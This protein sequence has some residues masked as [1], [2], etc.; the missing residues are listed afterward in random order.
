M[1]KLVYY[2]GFPFLVNCFLLGATWEGYIV[3]AIFSFPLLYKI[4]RIS[5]GCF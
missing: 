3:A 5:E 2:L 4:K 1:M